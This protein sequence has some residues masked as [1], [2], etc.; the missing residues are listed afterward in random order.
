MISSNITNIGTWGRVRLR[1]ATFE[2]LEFSPVPPSS[3]LR[4]FPE[5]T[6][7]TSP[8]MFL[9]WTTPRRST[10]MK[11]TSRPRPGC[12]SVTRWSLGPPA[13]SS[14]HRGQEESQPT[15][16]EGGEMATAVIGRIT[17]RLSTRNILGAYHRSNVPSPSSS[18]PPTPSSTTTTRPS[19]SP[20]ISSPRDSEAPSPAAQC[21]LITAPSSAAQQ[22]E[23]T[24][25]E[26]DEPD[27]NHEVKQK[28]KEEKKFVSAD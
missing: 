5:C 9:R 26:A 22:Q 6:P 18:E 4:M 20:W 16:Q 14:W 15:S 7:R 13:A 23:E 10:E 25:L 1:R 2:L 28:T 27:N 3:Y 21:R 19:S 17:E 11:M 24:S 8:S 12:S